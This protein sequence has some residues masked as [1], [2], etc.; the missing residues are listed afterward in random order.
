M[1]IEAIFVLGIGLMLSV[2]NVYFRDIQHF[3][4]IVLQ[5]LFY[6]AP[7]VYPITLRARSAAHVLGMT[8]PVRAIYDLNPL[9]RFV[10]CVPRRAVQPRVP[11]ASATSRYIIRVGD[12]R[13]WPSGSWVFRKL[14]RRL[15]EEV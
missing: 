12:R 9:V 7:I 3:M 5:A 11:A 8:I 10:E 4:S 1:L 15:A 6:S 14:D 13:C 2:L